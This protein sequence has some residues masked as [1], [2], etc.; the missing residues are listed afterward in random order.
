MPQTCLSDARVF[1]RL[2]ARNQALRNTFGES[3]L[4]KLAFLLTLEKFGFAVD[5]FVSVRACSVNEF[6][7]LSTSGLQQIQYES[8]SNF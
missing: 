8:F 7:Q 5:D 4:D 3:V 1:S 6:Q 2:T